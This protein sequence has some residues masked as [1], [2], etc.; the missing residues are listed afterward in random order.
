MID[1]RIG[2]NSVSGRRYSSGLAYVIIPFNQDRDQYVR[3]CL[4][5]GFLTVVQE[6]NNAFVVKC[7]RGILQSIDFPSEIGILGSQL[8]FVVVPKYKFPIVVANIDN[9][10]Q[11]NDLKEN[12]FR[13]FKQ[14]DVARVGIVG[15]GKGNL[16][17]SVSSDQDNKGQINI[18]LVNKNSSAK[19]NINTRGTFNLNVSGNTTIKSE[20]QIDVVAPKIN[21]NDGN[22]PMV[23]GDTLA[24]LLKDLIQLTSTSTN[25]G[26]PLSNAGDI[27]ALEQ[28]VD[29]ILSEKSNIE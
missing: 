8:A 4:R 12:Q 18:D 19:F 10:D 20:E 28:Q 5:T 27:A 16:S 2:T 3:E 9:L 24:Q 1:R 13:L 11:Y 6:E 7:D 21:H 26:G 14:T 25:S 15:D 17:I 22:E 23:L 29:N